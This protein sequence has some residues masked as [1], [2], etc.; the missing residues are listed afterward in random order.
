[1]IIKVAIISQAMMMSEILLRTNCNGHHYPKGIHDSTSASK[2]RS[3]TVFS[4][5]III[6][7]I[8]PSKA[9][10]ACDGMGAENEID[11]Q[12]PT[13]IHFLA[14]LKFMPCMFPAA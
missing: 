10:M 11:A 2:L 14:N 13:L 6:E 9:S 12:T 5:F 4:F 3:T 1:M 7:L 8:A